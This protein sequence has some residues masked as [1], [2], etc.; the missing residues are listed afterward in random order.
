[1]PPR[2]QQPL[3]R[4]PP[5]GNARLL[6]T[7]RGR[8]DGGVTVLRH[9][10]PYLQCVVL[11]CRCVAARTPSYHPHRRL[12]WYRAGP[13]SSGPPPCASTIRR[14][15]FTGDRVGHVQG[16]VVRCW[17]RSA[18][19]GLADERLGKPSM[20]WQVPKAVPAATGRSCSDARRAVGGQG[21]LARRIFAPKHQEVE[22]NDAR[23]QGSVPFDGFSING[24]FG[25]RFI[26]PR[27]IG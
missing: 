9:H 22:L 10:P 21:A 3:G 12:D 4:V 16:I 23:A 17:Q 1:M 26:S 15:S 6:A 8:G 25:M 27:R 7:R 14:P 20:V 2:Y 18:C 24:G 5:E 19:F 13:G 11:M